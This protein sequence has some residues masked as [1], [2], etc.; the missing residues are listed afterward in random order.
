MPRPVPTTAADARDEVQRLLGDW[1][2][3]A[4]QGVADEVVL[5]DALLVTTELVTNAIRHGGGLS[6]FQ[7]DLTERG[8]RVTVG[9]RSEVPPTV[10][11]PTNAEGTVRVGGYGWPLIRRLARDIAVI[12]APAARSSVSWCPCRKHPGPDGRPPAGPSVITRCHARA[13]VVMSDH[14][15]APA[16]AVRDARRT[17]SVAAARTGPDT[18]AHSPSSRFEHSAVISMTATRRCFAGCS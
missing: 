16:H 17:L 7:A 6:A 5:A 15:R 3:R 8:L 13:L 1:F 10:I 2:R 18:R 11:T 4:R 9:D 14:R 12:P